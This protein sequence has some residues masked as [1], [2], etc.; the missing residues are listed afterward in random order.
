ME[1]A[2][3]VCFLIFSQKTC[4]FRSKFWKISIYAISETIILAQSIQFFWYPNLPIKDWEKFSAF[5]N[6]INLPSTDVLAARL[7]LLKEYLIFEILLIGTLFFGVIVICLLKL[8]KKIVPRIVL[9]TCRIVSV[10]LCDLFFIPSSILLFVLCK[11]SNEKIEYISEYPNSI[12]GE[13]LN[14]GEAGRVLAI[15][16]LILIVVFSFFYE[17]CEYEIRHTSDEDF[18]DGK[19]HP[20][21]D[22][23]SKIVAFANCYMMTNLQLLDYET[24]L[25]AV[26]IMYS[27]TTLAFIYYLPYY[28]R[29][30]NFFK[31]FVNIDCLGIIVFFWFGYRVNNAGIIFLLGLI[32][33]IA[34]L[35][36]AYQIIL[37]RQSRIIHYSSS[38]YKSFEKFELSIRGLLKD[39]SLS[40]SL[41][42]ITNKNFKYSKSKLIPILQA[43]YCT[44][45]LENC[46]LGLN[47]IFNTSHKG[48]NIFTNYQIYKCKEIMISSCQ[49]YSDTYKFFRYFIDFDDI[50]RQDRKFCEVYFRFFGNVIEKKLN[51]SQIK[52]Q[53]NEI[54][55]MVENLK[56]GYEKLKARFP[57]ALEIKQIYGSLLLNLLSDLQQ[58]QRLMNRYSFYAA[59]SSSKV[60]NKLSKFTIDRC[61]IV[62]S[63][64]K[65]NIG[66]ILFHNKNFINL[67]GFPQ[68]S[69]KELNI[70]HL[71]PKSY[72]NS[73][74]HYMKKFL[75]NATSH[76]VFNR[77]P[78]PLL[79]SDNFLHE[80]LVSIECIG[81]ENSVNF[82]IAID[83][84]GY[85]KR[86][87]VLINDNGYM[88][89]H[90][91]YFPTLI[92]AN[93]KYVS[94]S[95]IQEYIPEINLNDFHDNEH[96][97]ISFLNKQTNN[98]TTVKTM[99]KILSVKKSRFRI[100]YLS[101]N[102]DKISSWNEDNFFA[103]D[104]I[105]DD[106]FDAPSTLTDKYSENNSTG[107]KK[108]K[109]MDNKSSGNQKSTDKS[110]QSSFS[111]SSLV[112]TIKEIKSFKKSILV[113]KLARYILLLLII[114]LIAASIAIIIYISQEVSHSNSL[115]ALNHL[116][117]QAFY[118]AQ[119]S[120]VLRCLHVENVANISLI[121]TLENA[122]DILIELK[123]YQDSL[124]KDYNSWSYCPSSNIVKQPIVPYWVLEKSPVL[125]Y[126]NL[127]KILELIIENVFII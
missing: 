46:T 8:F 112:M 99:N 10:F 116:N 12:K 37:I 101:N 100:F 4:T 83:S 97:E 5:W 94:N 72:A 13:T 108:V 54:M 115:I 104:D 19:I 23:L 31:I 67:F 24:Y 78:L 93:R 15:I 79:D 89:E 47:K 122:Q 71:I 117:N 125:K 65:H 36:V 7:D 92:G 56:E 90:S 106:E 86:E 102:I 80:C 20:K 119:L 87:Y 28:S 52:K 59:K 26:S 114:V 25:L 63:G 74:F 88:E 85:K 107:P 22:I 96:K 123:Y 38:Q 45:I 81:Y 105:D 18:S 120:L 68:E 44:D 95:F 73:H 53:V 11:Y 103:K 82:I 27:I 42:S 110:R 41:L 33:Q 3:S 76:I 58:G 50:K 126:T 91:K 35:F 64:N 127:H 121:Y 109:I 75:K 32:M 34:L 1:F 51:L 21:A 40:T 29:Y 70:K 118:M 55:T 66:Q 84:L 14:F 57:D 2:Y 17:T 48:L 69:I 16:L 30:L 39:G 60:P 98:M 43:Y 61:F 49:I 9:Y 113:L 124:L 6:I 111:T 77:A 62:V